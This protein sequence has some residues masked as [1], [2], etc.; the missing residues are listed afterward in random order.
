[1]TTLFRR[2]CGDDFDR[3][4]PLFAFTTHLPPTAARVRC[5]E[6]QNGDRF[7]FPRV[8]QASCVRKWKHSMPKPSRK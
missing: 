8:N 2:A 5:R 4:A 3:L 7:E 1:M 6:R